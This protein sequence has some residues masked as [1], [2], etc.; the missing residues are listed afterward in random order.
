MKG[1]VKAVMT[2]IGEDEIG[3]DTV[4]EQSSEA[5]AQLC[6]WQLAIGY[7]L[8]T[9]EVREEMKKSLKGSTVGGQ[10]GDLASGA[11]E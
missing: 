1:L 4:T 2:G 11:F 6:M 9:L 7:N 3:P 10:D 8:R 5:M